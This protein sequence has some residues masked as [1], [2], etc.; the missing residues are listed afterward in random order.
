MSLKD[1]FDLTGQVAIVTGGARGIGAACAAGLAEF[2]A[3]LA[4]VDLLGDLAAETA[5]RLAAQY[6][7]RAEAFP[8][9]VT[10]SAAV[11]GMVAQV[12][13]AFGRVD[14]LLNSAGI[15]IWQDSAT[16]SDEQWRQVL[17][18]NLTGAFYLSRAVARPMLKQRTGS[19]VHIA[20]M[21]GSIANVPQHQAAYNAS[22][23]GLIH[24]VRSL[25]QEWAP[26]G[27][28]VNCLSPGYTL[29]QMTYTV[30]EHFPAWEALIPMGRLAE[31]EELVGAVVYL[32]S[33][34]SSYTTGH[35]LVV[36][37][38]YTLR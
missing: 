33:E 23:A 14:V 24:L 38:G 37:G 28:R 16:M 1:K 21:S 3:Q 9:D 17:D 22:K 31:P 8:C 6:G 7:V 32:A 5:S 35:D 26:Y 19:M 36:D 13:V 18:L 4:L 30:Q 34:A 2:G 12:E 15:C 11:D 25:A 10:D 29:S 27:V 20:S